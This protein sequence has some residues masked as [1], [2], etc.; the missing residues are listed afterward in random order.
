[1]PSQ[2]WDEKQFNDWYSGI[3]IPWVTDFAYVYRH[4]AYI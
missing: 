2:V 1:M 4:L 3:H